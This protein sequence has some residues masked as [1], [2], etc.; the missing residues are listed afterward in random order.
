[1]ATTSYD[2][3]PEVGRPTWATSSIAGANIRRGWRLLQ[4]SYAAL[5][6]IVGLDKFAIVLVDWAGYLAPSVAGILP[7][8]PVRLMWGVGVF[9]IVLAMLLAFRPRVGGALFGVWLLLTAFNLFLH[10][11]GLLDLALR[12]IVLALGAFA[13][14]VLSRGLD[15]RYRGAD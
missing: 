1:M 11:A 2:F 12:D 13:L 9:E 3:H 7:T 5:A 10:P 6:L 15:R 8:S 14:G 4:F